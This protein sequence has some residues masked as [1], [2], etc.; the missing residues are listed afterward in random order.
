[1]DEYKAR[2][3]LLAYLKTQDHR[4][5]SPKSLMPVEGWSPML[6][7]VATAHDEHTGNLCFWACIVNPDEEWLAFNWIERLA[8]YCMKQMAPP[9]EDPLEYD[10]AV[11]I[12]QARELVEA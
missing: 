6:Y 9:G 2:E 1:M 5:L 3:A 7:P 8:E 11:W 12:G 4:Y 10:C